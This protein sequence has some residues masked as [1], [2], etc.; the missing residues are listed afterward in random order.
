NDPSLQAYAP[1]IKQLNWAVDEAVQGSL[2]GQ[3]GPDLYGSG[4]ASYT[5]QGMFPAPGLAGGGS[6]PAQV[7]F[8]VLTQESNLEQASSHVITGQTGNFLP[9]Y[10]WYGNWEQTPSGPSDLGQVDWANVDCGYG[11]AQITSGMCMA[12]NPNCPSVDGPALPADQ[13]KAVAIDYQANIAAG[14]QVLEQKWNELHDLGITAN[15][16]DPQYIENWWFALWD[17]NTGLQPNAAHGNTSGCSPSPSCTDSGGNW[18][19]GWLNNP[20]NDIYPP[21]R[22]GFLDASSRTTPDGGSY[23]AA[24]D[25]AHPQ[26]WSY[27]EKVIGFAFNAFTT[28]NYVDAQWEQAYPY[29][30]WRNSPDQVDPALPALTALCTAQNQCDPTTIDPGSNQTQGADPCQQTGALE[31]H[32]WW[33]WSLNWLPTGKSCAD[34]CGVQV[35]TFDPGDPDP[36][37]DGVP[38]G[39]APDCSTSGTLPSNAVIVDDVTTPAAL[40]CPGKNWSTAGSISWSFGSDNSTGTYPSKIDF[41]QIGAGFGGHFWVTHAI[42]S[43]QSNLFTSGAVT[44]TV[45]ADPSLQITGTW[46]PPSSMTGWTRVM[47]HIPNYGAWTPD[48]D[49]QVNPG[50]GGATT[51]RIVNQAQQANTWVDLG[52]FDLG[53]GASVS[54]S[55]VSWEN[56]PNGT[57]AG[58]DIA[59]DAAAFIPLGR[60][61]GYGY[62]AMGDSY[63][64]GEGVAPYAADSDYNYAG[65][66]QTCHR[67]TQAYPELVRLPGNQTTIAQQAA[68][69]G[70]ATS[71]TFMACSG[72]ETNA[73]SWDPG[74][75]DNPKTAWDAAGYTDWGD[76]QL[77]SGAPSDPTDPANGVL[78]TVQS[79][80][81]ELP[82]AAQG[83][84]S[85][86][87]KLVTITAGG[88]DARFGDIMTACVETD[89]L[90]DPSIPG[91]SASGYHLQRTDLAGNQVTDPQPLVQMEPAVIQNLEPHL[92]ALYRAVAAAAPNATILVIGYPD[93]FPGGQNATAC[94]VYAGVTLTGPDVR[95]LNSMGDQMDLQTLYAA[96]AVGADT[97]RVFYLDPN[98]VFQDHRICDPVPWIN[99]VVT[100]ESSNSGW[101]TPGNNSFHPNADGQAALARL[102]NNFLATGAQQRR[103]T[104]LR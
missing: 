86:Q 29:G 53:A 55:N 34:V 67:S 56:S 30:L 82:Q 52:F 103:R 79:T 47:V 72:Q 90:T 38:P 44:R 96:T 1:S 23:S 74:V 87:T 88:N 76:P 22:P 11:M 85:P 20:A 60:S 35:L 95:W 13:Q 73:M 80:A 4:L 12:G 2:T 33:H 40:G 104:G 28:Y 19:L 46:R 102:V 48:A 57:D 84:L 6:V 71:F 17:Y 15:D 10:N 61:P 16:G 65:M 101:S 69:P 63:S 98:D 94:T 99:G 32:C 77:N 49:Y 39:Y 5:P 97:G 8:G 54:L 51:Y 68:Q 91:C 70:S 75:V 66:I 59:W 64:A 45:P 14:L 41:H 100:K 9:S 42:P 92:E 83:W 37:S 3:R 31:D 89:A 58:Y 24:W 26:F 27:E 21:D 78:P 18:G 93:L 43:D 50:G 62:V 25:Q 7:L 81:G 36:G